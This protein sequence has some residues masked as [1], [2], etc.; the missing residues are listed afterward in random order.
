MEFFRGEKLALHIEKL[1]QTSAGELPK[2]TKLPLA[3]LSLSNPT[4]T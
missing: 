3:Q 4:R 1:M 2:V